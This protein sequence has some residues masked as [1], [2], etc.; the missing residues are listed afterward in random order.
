M[1]WLKNYWGGAV[2]VLFA[3]GWL[4]V[5]H[6]RNAMHQRAHYTIG[7]LT[8]WHPTPKSGIYYNYRFSVADALYEG[9]SPGEAGMP[10]GIGTRCVV[11]YDSLNPNSNF[12]YF[13]LTIPA[14]IR[15]APSTGWRVPP[16]PIPQ[17]ML[18]RGKQR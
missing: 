6:S 2:L 14:S 4:W 16:F 13:K 11:E 3:L 15:Q 1:Q 18:D 8:G 10:T 12:A 9:S 17:W 7:Y 5:R